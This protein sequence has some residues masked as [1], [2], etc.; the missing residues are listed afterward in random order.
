MYK[1]WAILTMKPMADLWKMERFRCYSKINKSQWCDALS[2]TTISDE[3]L[4][5]FVPLLS[6]FSF[7]YITTY[8]SRLVFLFTFPFYHPFSDRT[9][10]WRRQKRGKQST[11]IHHTSSSQSRLWVI[12]KNSRVYLIITSSLRN[13]WTPSSGAE[14]TSRVV[15]LIF[16]TPLWTS[17]VR[18][19]RQYSHKTVN[20]I[21][22]F[23]LLRESTNIYSF[24]E[25]LLQ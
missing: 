15:S 25:N 5:P 18:N 20:R 19:D 11:A 23:L 3:T 13:I 4:T 12:A 9:R 10:R 6:S 17:S 14:I 16:Q 2:I 8:K 24:A 1:C 21:N 7:Y 22:F